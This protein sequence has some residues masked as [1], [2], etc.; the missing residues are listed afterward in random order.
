MYSKQ[1][2]TLFT[3][4]NSRKRPEDIAQ[5]ILELPELQLTQ[6]TMSKLKLSAEGALSN[7]QFGYSSMSDEFFNPIGCE[8][9]LNKGK[10]LFPSVVFEPDNGTL[11]QHADTLIEQ[12]CP[13]LG[14]APSKLDFK[15]DRL[16][17]LERKAANLD[18][19]KRQYNKKFRYLRRLQAKRARLARELKKREFTLISKSGLAF[20]I[21]EHHF[22]DDALTAAFIAYY[23]ARC[24]LRSE[25]TTDKQQR[26]YDEIAHQLFQDCMRANSTNW[27]AISHV[28]P[29]PFVLSKLT[30]EQKG[31]M[32]GTWYSVLCELAE[33]L[34]ELW[35]KSDISRKTMIVKRGNDS[36]TWNN[37]AGAWNKVRDA[38]FRFLFDL[39]MQDIV[40]VLCPGKVLRLM[41][42]DVVAWHHHEEGTLEVDT[43]IWNEVPLPWEV[44]SGEAECSRHF[45]ERV[46]RRY[47]VDPVH[48]GWTAPPPDIQVAKF[49]LTPE[50]VHGVTVSNPGLAKVLKKTGVFS[51]K[52]VKD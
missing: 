32:L 44:L 9:Q 17:K 36:T 47:G 22:F 13:L 1:Y 5:V 21:D 50:L 51:G 12:A 6:E 43:K 15:H 29:A 27:W 26:P 23:V 49:R 34:K 8:K 39:G 45:V 31:K 52:P 33:F 46:C 30:D 37:T 11:P 24:N 10:E 25:Y 35:G 14:G 42:A 3:S 18:I 48:K 2:R 7:N 38:W 40:D 28:Y 41:A 4:L 16:N 19:S 20:T